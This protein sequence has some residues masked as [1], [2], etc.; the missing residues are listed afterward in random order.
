MIAA[1]REEVELEMEEE[2]ALGWGEQG[3]VKTLQEGVRLE[4][5]Q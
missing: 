4:E 5:E 2:E 1:P 3:L